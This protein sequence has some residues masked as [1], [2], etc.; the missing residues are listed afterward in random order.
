[1]QKNQKHE[2]KPLEL[3]VLLF[4]GLVV[5]RLLICFQENDNFYVRQG[6]GFFAKMD[7]I[8]LCQAV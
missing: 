3:A 4:A 2:L 1:M 8:N 5:L 6:L 7:E